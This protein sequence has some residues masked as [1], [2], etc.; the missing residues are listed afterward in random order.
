MTVRAV[1]CRVFGNGGFS[2]FSFIELLVTLAIMSVLLT[3][4]VPMVQV[5]VQRQQ[6]ND[7][8]IALIQ[9]R[10]ALDAYKKASE[11]GRI[12]LKVGESGYPATPEQL[13]DGVDDQRSP[14]RQKLYFLRRLPRDPFHHRD[15]ETAAALTWGLRS[16]ASPPTNPAQRLDVFDVYSKSDRIG[17][18]GVPYRDW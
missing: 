6:E 8:R 14:T 3:V 4:A 13:V 17:L 11:Q 9:I 7:L 10:E 5:A 18:N 12:A 2:G 15:F 1:D 16:Y